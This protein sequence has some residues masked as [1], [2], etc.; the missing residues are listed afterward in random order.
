MD[1][2]QIAE[3]LRDISGTLA[4]RWNCESALMPFEVDD[5][6]RDLDEIV[7]AIEGIPMTQAE[8]IENGGANC[9]VCRNTRIHCCT[10][11]GR[12]ERYTCDNCKNTWDVTYGIE[13]YSGVSFDTP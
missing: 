10:T 4:A 8:F 2:K 12:S 5:A 11:P 3:R 1:Q 13:R 7:N 6:I 9:P